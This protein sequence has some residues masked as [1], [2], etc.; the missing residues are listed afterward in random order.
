MIRSTQQPTHAGGVVVREGASEREYLLV[1]ARSA[2]PEWVLPKGHIEWG[3]TAEQAAV[4]EVKEE[5]G[6]TARVIAGLGEVEIPAKGRIIL[7][8]FFLMIAES[9]GKAEED[10]AKTW[11]GIEEAMKAASHDQTRIMVQRAGDLLAMTDG[12]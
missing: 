5:A 10:R 7:A 4:R 2:A 9:E 11:L 8:A 1:R 12:R 3:E 6:V